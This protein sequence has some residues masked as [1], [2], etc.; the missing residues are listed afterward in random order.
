VKKLAI[1]LSILALAA[2][3]GCTT[4]EVA[5][6]ANTFTSAP[7][8]GQPVAYHTGTGTVTRIGYSPSYSAAAGGSTVTTPQRMNRLTIRMDNG[9]V[10]Y[11]D[12]DSNEFRSGMRVELLPDR[13]IRIVDAPI[14]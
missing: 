8:V 5:R 6:P 14:R 4:Y 2:A 12:T 11:L 3:G 1:P 7:I 9:A 13:T 10:Q